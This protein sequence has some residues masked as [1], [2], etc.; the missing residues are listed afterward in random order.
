MAMR[1]RHTTRGELLLS[2]ARQK[3]TQQRRPSTPKMNKQIKSFEK[4][5]IISAF[6]V[7]AMHCL[8]IKSTCSLIGP[9]PLKHKEQMRGSIK[10]R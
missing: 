9:P 7:V 5:D 2:A 3:P 10:L 4:D 1:C 6:Q 8:H